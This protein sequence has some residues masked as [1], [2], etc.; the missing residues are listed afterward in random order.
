MDRAP[1]QPFES[2]SAPFFELRSV[3]AETVSLGCLSDLFLGGDGRRVFH[4]TSL[5]S[6]FRRS[7]KSSTVTHALREAVLVSR[8]RSLLRFTGC[9]RKNREPTRREDRSSCVSRSAENSRRGCCW[10][11]FKLRCQEG[12]LHGKS[13]VLVKWLRAVFSAAPSSCRG[14]DP[15]R[16]LPPPDIGWLM[17]RGL[18]P[19]GRA[20]TSS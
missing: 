8:P 13:R 11:R 1:S 12:S 20:H 7:L 6:I 17:P 5:S 3:Y 10:R 18:S 9:V 16:S 19:W 15:R 2:G 14:V 4:R